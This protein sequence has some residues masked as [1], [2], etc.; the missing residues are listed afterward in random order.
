VLNASEF[1]T[2]SGIAN[3]RADSTAHIVYDSTTGSLYYDANGG[4]ANDAVKFATL[5][6]ASGTFDSSD[7]KIGS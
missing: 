7:I 1:S 2:V 4:T 5:T 6:I 3:V